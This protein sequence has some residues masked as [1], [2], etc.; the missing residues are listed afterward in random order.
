MPRAFASDDDRD[1]IQA[2][3]DVASAFAGLDLDLGALAAVSNVFRAATAVRNHIERTVLDAHALSWSAFTVLFVLRVWGEQESRELAEEAGITGGTLTGV[4]KT[5]E[6]KGLALRREH[7]LDRRRVIVAATDAGGRVV[8]D[9]MPALNKHEALVSM[10]LD[11]EERRG[12]VVA[13]RKVLRTVEALDGTTGTRVTA[14]P[15]AG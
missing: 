1:L 9:I 12:L 10:S 5:L 15:P 13:L 11:E 4:L 8:D 6:R 3:R 2:E 7:D 14:D